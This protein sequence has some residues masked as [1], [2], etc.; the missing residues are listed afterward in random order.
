MLKEWQKEL[1]NLTNTRESTNSNKNEEIKNL[2]NNL[3]D[4]NQKEEKKRETLQND[5]KMRWEEN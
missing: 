4:F 5:S 3:F 2:W 1:E